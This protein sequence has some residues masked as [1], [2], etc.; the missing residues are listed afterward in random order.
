MQVRCW[1]AVLQRQAHSMLQKQ[2]NDP[3]ACSSAPLQ[4]APAVWAHPLAGT[5]PR[6]RRRVRAGSGALREDSGEHLLGWAGV[7]MPVAP[8]SAP[9]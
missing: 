9:L 3:P 5:A 6:L 8:Q 4:S 7:R 2:V 1:R